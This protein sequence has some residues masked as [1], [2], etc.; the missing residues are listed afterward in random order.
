MSD[1]ESL[2]VSLSDNSLLPGESLD[3]SPSDNSLS[4]GESL[5]SDGESLDV[6]PSDNS[7]SPSESL[8]SDGESP[9]TSLP[10]NSCLPG[11][12]LVS[13]SESANKS[14]FVICR[15]TVG[16]PRDPLFWRGQRDGFIEVLDKAKTYQSEVRVKRQIEQLRKD[17]DYVLAADERLSY[18]TY[19]ELIQM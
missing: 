3:V 4:P 7:L 14:R 6:S 18:K 8:V 1:G 12:S 17:P 2:D 5:V 9:D 13:D 19:G 10:D 11:E 16:K 15:Y